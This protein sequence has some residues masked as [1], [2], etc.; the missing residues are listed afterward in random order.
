MVITTNSALIL[1]KAT[2]PKGLM[3]AFYMV[4]A[5][6]KYYVVLFFLFDFNWVSETC[7]SGLSPPFPTAGQFGLSIKAFYFNQN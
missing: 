3:D 5:T 4:D 2:H 6:A 7:L 1:I